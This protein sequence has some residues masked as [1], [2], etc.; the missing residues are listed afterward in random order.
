MQLAVKAHGI[1]HSSEEGQQFTHWVIGQFSRGSRMADSL[2][3]V[4]PSLTAADE[5]R[6]AVREDAVHGAE[7]AKPS[8]VAS[9]VQNAMGELAVAAKPLP[10]SATPSPALS[11]PPNTPPVHTA[12]P[13]ADQ[14]PTAIVTA[15]DPVNGSALA[16]PSLA[17]AARLTPT[18]ATTASP[19]DFV[20]C[21]VMCFAHSA[22]TKKVRRRGY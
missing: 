2:S 5:K 18:I 10:A 9:A 4:S 11:T 1:P 19:D 13:S 15:P 6:V 17:P 21:D 16:E 22:W 3:A 8:P 20:I 14:S 12:Q 7:I